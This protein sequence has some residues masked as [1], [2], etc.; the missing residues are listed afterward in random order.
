[1]SHMNTLTFSLFT[2]FVDTDAFE[3]LFHLVLSSTRV[4]SQIKLRSYIMQKSFL[5]SKRNIET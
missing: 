1:M 2:I 5:N 3:F 4:L